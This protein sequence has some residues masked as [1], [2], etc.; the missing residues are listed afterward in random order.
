M[1]PET[2]TPSS[3]GFHIPNHTSHVLRSLPFGEITKLPERP[4]FPTKDAM[5]AW[6][7]DGATQGCF[8]NLAEPKE[9]ARRLTKDNAV[10]FLHG[11]IADYDTKVSRTQLIEA[12]AKFPVDFKPAFASTT[13][14]GG[15]RIVWLFEKKLPV[16]SPEICKAVLLR[17]KKETKAAKFL[18]GLDE[19]AFID[20]ARY[21][22]LGT[23]WLELDKAARISSKALAQFVFEASSKVDWRDRGVIIPMEAIAAEVER[24][25]PGRWTG[26]FAVGAMGIRW[27]DSSATHDSGAWI[28]ESGVQAF[29]G[30]GR[31]LPWA[32]ILGAE[33]VS[34]FERERVGGA[35]DGMYF[36]GK[37]YWVK[38]GEGTWCDNNSENTQRYLVGRG[39]RKE[40]RRGEVSEVERAMTHLA[41][42]AR[43]AGAFPFLYRNEDIVRI[44]HQ[45][46]LNTLKL[47]PVQPDATVR[48][49]GDGFP[50]IAKYLGEIF[51]TDNQLEIFLSWL[52]HFYR[53]ALEFKV[54]KGQAI[55]VSGDANVG[56]TFLSQRVIGGLMGGVG[57]AQRYLL[58][59]EQY[60]SSLFEKPVWTIDDAVAGA[61][62]KSHGRYSQIIKKTVANFTLV[63]R[64]MFSD[65]LTLPWEGR[66]VVTLND[67]P[68]SILMLP[69]IDTS[70]LDKVMFFKA[71]K[72]TVSFGGAE[73]KVAAE[74][75]AFASFLAAHKIPE[76]LR[77]DERYGV[78]PY[79]NA[80][81]RQRANDNSKGVEFLQLLHLWR[82][83]YFLSQDE[84][85]TEWVGNSTALITEM[86]E[87]ESLK[88]LRQAFANSITV[89]KNL[90]VVV[91]KNV[92]WVSVHG[93]HNELGT[94]FRIKRPQAG[95]FP[96]AGRAST[97]KPA[98]RPIDGMNP[99]A[100]V[101]AAA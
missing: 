61:D 62:P 86:A 80:E 3:L 37:A 70:M 50:W 51:A 69:N 85:V 41:F 66:I 20:P 4:A 90:N 38:D 42:N 46:F 13:F 54:R 27:W 72:T 76:H 75:P 93:R 57:E 64:R 47:S 99:E 26:P 29:S 91:R 15:A 97:V 82:T 87:C 92:G 48:S 58:G 7:H 22:E 14:S 59:E 94:Q 32:E 6:A 55:F 1:T 77:G 19:P 23:D 78:K 8:Y 95:E 9:P 45:K 11:V 33:F 44:G 5:L 53:S 25:W 24:R 52:G 84:K 65:P 89:G 17:L 16:Y 60:N 68:E 98:G 30:E 43:V 31:F 10:A 39:L 67:D 79:H 56:K 2:Q 21:F 18:G 96:T 35:V 83:S 28:R 34:R 81:L 36:D 74:M 100:P 12:V 40:G 73:A 49:W 71:S 101:S 88:G 63:Y